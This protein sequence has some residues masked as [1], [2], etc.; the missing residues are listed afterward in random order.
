MLPHVPHISVGV[1][2]VQLIIRR[3]IKNF[4][5]CDTTLLEVVSSTLEI[6]P[7]VV[8]IEDNP[9]HARFTMNVIVG[10]VIVVGGIPMHC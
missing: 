3:V 9:R 2:K 5:G 8:P 4:S 7:G 10:K 1:Y 6:V